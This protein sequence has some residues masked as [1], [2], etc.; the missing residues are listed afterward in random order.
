MCVCADEL[1]E[2]LAYLDVNP[3]PDMWLANI[4]PYSIGCP[5]ILLIIFFAVEKFISS[6]SFYVFIFVA[7][8]FAIKS[9]NLLLRPISRSLLPMFSSSTFGFYV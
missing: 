7:F 4:S 9:N 8:A 5:F 2:S 1:C 3:L 6:M